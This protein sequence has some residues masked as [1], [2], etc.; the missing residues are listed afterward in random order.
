MR[1]KQTGQVGNS[2]SAGVGGATGFEFREADVRE[3]CN[4]VP[5]PV[6]ISVL[7]GAGVNGSLLIS[8]K[9]GSWSS[10]SGICSSM[11]FMKTT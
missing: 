7:G 6:D 9:E 1:S 3:D 5:V 8:G 4:T 11:D 10:A 2:I